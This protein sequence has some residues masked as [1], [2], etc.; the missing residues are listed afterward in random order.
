M[1]KRGV[2]LLSAL[3]MALALSP[4]VFGQAVTASVVGQ[5]SDSTGALLPGAKV[6]LTNQQTSITTTALTNESGNYE[7]SY[8][9]PGVYAVSVTHQNFE[10]SVRRNIAVIVNSTVRVDVKLTVGSVDQTVTINS[11]APTIETDRADV[12]GVITPEQTAELPLGNNRN[13]QAL[14]TLLPG[15][16]PTFQDHSSFMN[17]QNALN[18]DVNGQDE[19]S[20]NIQIEGIDDNVRSGE[21]QGAYIPPAAA[22]QTVDVE[23]NNYAP[24]FGRATGA[25]TNV[26]LKSGTNQFHGSLYEYNSVAATSARSYFNNTAPLPGFTN[27]YW[28]GTIGGPIRKNHTFFFADFLRYSNHDALYS[29]FTIPTQ[30]FDTGDLSASPTA[31]YDPATG[32][33]NGTGRQQFVTNGVANVIPVSRIDPISKALIALL[34]PPNLPGLTNNWQGNLPFDVDTESVDGKLDQDVGKSDHLAV[35][36]SFEQVKTY[37][38]PAFGMA[39]GPGGTTAGFQGTGLDTIYAIGIEYTH[40]FS[41]T[42]VMEARAG[43]DHYWNT[44]EQSDY[45]TDASTAIGIPGINTSP[46]NSGITTIQVEGYSTPTI[47]YNNGLP[48][49][50]GETNIDMVN[51]WT[52]I[53]KNHTFK[54]GWEIRRV[55]DDLLQGQSPNPRGVYQYDDGQTALNAT[56]SPASG[57]ANAWAAF[58]LDVPDSAGLAA[59]VS[60]L[61]WRQSQYF[62]FAQDT[63]QLSRKL[64]VTYGLRYEVY[65]PYKP[66]VPGGFSD[67]DPSTNSYEIAGEGSVPLDLG[68]P[69]NKANFAPRLGIAY[70]PTRNTVVRAGFGISY[71]PMAGVG[72]AHNYPDITSY[73]YPAPTTYTAALNASGKAVLLSQ[74]FPAVTPVAIPSDGILPAPIGEAGTVLNTKYKDPYVMSYSLTV[75]RILPGGWTASVAYVGNEGRQLNTSWNLDPGLVAGA[76]EAG[77][78]LYI[79]FGQTASASLQYAGTN[80]TYNSLQARLDHHFSKGLLWSS[81]YAWQKATGFESGGVSGPGGLNFYLPGTFHRN[82]GVLLYNSPQTYSQSFLYE[83]PFGQNQ[84][85]LSNSSSVIRSIVGGWKLSDIWFMGVGFPITFTA[86]STGL[87]APSTDQVPDLVA[88]FKKLKGI[89]P[90][91]PWFDT[92][93]FAT[94]VGT[95]LGNMGLNDYSG[96]GLIT[97]NTSLL[98]DFPIHE[99]K[100]LEFRMDALNSLNHPTFAIPTAAM[101]SAS[102]GYVTATSQSYA[103]R[104][105]QFAATLNF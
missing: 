75:E 15:V 77:Q 50:R 84:R 32:N 92:S 3:S 7:F 41:P 49:A 13:F 37:Q 89:G 51:N 83:L 91:K 96:P 71:D 9:L 57:F 47:G 62:G 30:A 36:Y 54:F 46:F 24:E 61:A 64:T 29:L 6:T 48:W 23:T 102:F 78:P 73:N 80:S 97:N 85:F 35:R 86:S 33:A 67:Y 100:S 56:P 11:E 2:I 81:S 45:G 103:A 98:R 82:Y 4:R 72:Y 53:V 95:A 76:G 10:R 38:G 60:D 94:P 104:T 20:S 5:V 12:V 40:V 74:G 43:V 8:V 18:F 88:P 70:R 39:G 93:S 28:G 44:A 63:Y 101:T 52:K 105:L 14:T 16:S 66:R 34:P 79:K 58:L 55:R 42:L 90:T 25:V 22:L 17:A 31:I 21:L 19:L 27:N 87:D 69:W 26:I 68:M 99:S 1:S 59:S 65:Q